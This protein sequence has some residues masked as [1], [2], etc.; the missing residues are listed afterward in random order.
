MSPSA[1]SASKVELGGAI[2]VNLALLTV[3]TL[4]GYWWLYVALWV[5]P[6]FIWFP[7]IT[8]I[9]NIAEHAVVPDNDDPFRNARTTRANLLWRACV[10][11]Y[12]V[13]YHVEHHMYPGVPCYHLPRLRKLLEADLG[14]ATFGLRGI[15]KA[16]REDHAAR[17]LGDCSMQNA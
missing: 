9:R 6:F 5:V 13:N 14:P 7:T 17:S 10:A 4:L 16:M 15:V 12:W 11:P 1:R 2:A 8:R 3:L